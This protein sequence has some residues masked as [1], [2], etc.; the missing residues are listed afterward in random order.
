MPDLPIFAK[1]KCSPLQRHKND[2]ELL[3]N[4]GVAETSLLFR[5]DTNR[6]GNDVHAQRDIRC[7]GC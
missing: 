7:G 5:G 4:P 2:T 1:T 3:L 6:T